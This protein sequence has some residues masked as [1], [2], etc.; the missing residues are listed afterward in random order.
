[1]LRIYARLRSVR[2]ALRFPPV[3][4]GERSRGEALLRPRRLPRLFGVR[5]L[6]S[7]LW[8]E[9]NLRTSVR[10]DAAGIPDQ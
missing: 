5:W 10:D 1:M 6:V 3:R 9:T 2:R 7:A 8:P 4:R